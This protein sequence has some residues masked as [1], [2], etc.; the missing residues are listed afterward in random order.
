VLADCCVCV[1]ACAHCMFYSSRE[2]DER[3]ITHALFQPSNQHSWPFH[4]HQLPPSKDRLAS[5]S[6]FIFLTC[7][8]LSRGGSLPAGAR[9]PADVGRLGRVEPP[10]LALKLFGTRLRRPPEARSSSLDAGE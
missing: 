4:S 5:M 7:T 8:K 3:N 9:R 6:V 10:L 1:C 2:V